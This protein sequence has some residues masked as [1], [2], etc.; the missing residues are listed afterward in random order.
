VRSARLKLTIATAAL[1]AAVVVVAGAYAG[2]PQ[3]G[4]LLPDLVQ[5]PP[6]AVQVRAAG[7][8]FR[9]GFGSAVTNRGAGPLIIEA[10]RPSR[11][12]AGMSATQLIRREDGRTLRRPGV[13]AV[14][15]ARE[16]GH[17]HWHLLRFDRYTLRHAASDAVVVA[18]RKTG[19][20]LGDRFDASVAEQLPGEPAQPPFTRNCGLRRPDLLR[21]SEGI[22]VG[23]G[24]DYSAY[25]E[26]QYLDI[27]GIPAGRYE[28]V[29][30]AN[31][32]ERLLEERYDNNAACV[33]VLLTWPRGMQA[34]PAIEQ[35]PC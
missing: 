30:H 3:Q 23:Y 29:H 20:C 34:K 31:A 33:A 11:R 7:D 10:R 26:G 8:R 21:V 27:T 22:S 9:L 19:F 32:D 24:D 18:D 1:C 17:Q 2:R 4:L 25:L 35:H 15:Y 13:G 12:S 16:D 14:R 5:E 6:T 28:L